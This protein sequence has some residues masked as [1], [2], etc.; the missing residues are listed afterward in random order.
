MLNAANGEWPRKSVRIKEIKQGWSKSCFFSRWQKATDESWISTRRLKK[1]CPNSLIAREIEQIAGTMK[2]IYSQGTVRW[3]VVEAQISSIRKQRYVYA[4]TWWQ[5]PRHS[6][7]PWG[8]WCGSS[9]ELRWDIRTVCWR[10]QPLLV[11]KFSS[12]SSSPPSSESCSTSS[13]L[14]GRGTSR[15]TR[16]WSVL[17]ICSFSSRTVL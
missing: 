2:W 17:P 4:F 9:S 14:Y 8:N 1:S 3:N 16:Y 12:S 15:V 7:A 5:G 13:K 10:L 11:L 6:Q